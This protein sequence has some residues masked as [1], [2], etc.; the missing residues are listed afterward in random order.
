ME[1]NLFHQISSKY[2]FPCLS[3]MTALRQNVMNCHNTRQA[4]ESFFKTY[5]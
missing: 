3:H 5:E 4:G 2:T 1:S